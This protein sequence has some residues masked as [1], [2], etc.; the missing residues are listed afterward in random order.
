[1]CA[2][3]A[4]IISWVAS[5]I[6]YY[7]FSQNPGGIIKQ[8]DYL[9]NLDYFFK[10]FFYSFDQTIFEEIPEYSVRRMDNIISIVREEL[11][12]KTLDQL[13]FKSTN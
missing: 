10:F 1:M 4:S 3:I 13:L 5:Y 7:Y 11:T 6:Q 8:F 9:K 2:K 12:S